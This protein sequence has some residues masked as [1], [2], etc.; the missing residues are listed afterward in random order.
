[1]D[2]EKYY[3]NLVNNMFENLKKSI[4]CIET[5]PKT[6]II[7]Y[8]S[9]LELLFKA[10]LFKEHWSFILQNIDDKKANTNNFKNGDFL[11]VS[12]DVAALRI[13]NLLQ[14]LDSGYEKH[15]EDLRK[16][17]N[18]LVHFDCVEPKN[19]N[20]SISNISKTW[21][22][23]YNLLNKTWKDIFANH[24]KEIKEINEKMR[25]YSDFFWDSKKDALIKKNS[26]K[27]LRAPEYKILKVHNK[28]FIC[29]C[30][31]KS[32]DNENKLSLLKT[33]F[34]VETFTL[35]QRCDI[36]EHEDYLF[37]FSFYLQ[38]NK[39]TNFIINELK[40]FI[41][42]NLWCHRGKNS[43]NESHYKLLEKASFYDTHITFDD[44]AY[45]GY[46][47]YEIEINPINKMGSEIRLKFIT[48]FY[49]NDECLPAYYA[50]YTTLIFTLNIE[51]EDIAKFTFEELYN[52]IDDLMVE[53]FIDSDGF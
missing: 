17:R 12:F 29:I 52:S 41:N 39:S 19:P 36:C 48:D 13:Q 40:K 14:D 4:D 34:D 24:K 11:T 33:N 15:F 35:T 37:L 2:T 42:E 27:Y 26:N 5:D 44:I 25:K 7:S 47:D 9:A 20:L 28:P 23:V 45:F 51:K 6:S 43:V 16:F 30:C 50:L 38:K 31:N 8:F 32:Y 10:R 3:N 18:Q 49:I 21:Y 22:Y 46:D 53:F 1:M